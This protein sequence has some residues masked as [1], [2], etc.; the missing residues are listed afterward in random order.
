MDIRID[1]AENDASAR[2]EQVVGVE[3][4]PPGFESCQDGGEDTQMPPGKCLNAD[5]PPGKCDAL[6][7]DVERHHHH[8]GHE[9]RAEQ[10]FL[11]IGEEGKTEHIKSQ[12]L[13][14]QWDHLIKGLLMLEQKEDLP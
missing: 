2:V 6:R 8:G 14:E 11:K 10:P 12:N 13:S 3:L 4:I 1:G 7:D 5:H 9:H